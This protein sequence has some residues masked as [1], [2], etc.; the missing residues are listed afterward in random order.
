MFRIVVTHTIQNNFFLLLQNSDCLICFGCHATI[1]C[2]ERTQQHCADCHVFI[3]HCS[4]HASVCGSKTWIH[5]KYTSLY[6]NCL[7]RRCI[8]SIDVPFRFW[9]DGCWRKGG[10]GLEM[11]SPL[12]AFFR[13][14]S[15]HDL[16]LLSHNFIGIRIGVVVKDD[17][18]LMEKLWLGTSKCQLATAFTVNKEFN[19][20]DTHSRHATLLLAMSAEENPCITLHVFPKNK[21]T[22]DYVVRYDNAT[23][24]FDIP[25]GLRTQSIRSTSADMVA[26]GAVQPI[27][28]ELVDC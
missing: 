28:A 4:D 15:D 8:I 26:D 18:K 12:G 23:K 14:E 5:K 16:C 1:K 20:N 11:Y 6:A 7:T 10:D 22:R 27:Y 19:R 9:M 25:D 13:F 24:M 3:R 21:M 2:P 17:G